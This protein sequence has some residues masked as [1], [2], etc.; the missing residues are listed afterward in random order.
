VGEVDLM[1]TSTKTAGYPV[2][3]VGKF[4]RWTNQHQVH[5]TDWLARC[6]ARG[7]ESGHRPF[8]LAGSAR[9]LELCPTCF[10]GRDWNGAGAGEP[11]ELTDRTELKLK[12]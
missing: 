12:A 7:S 6:G 8:G 5:F 11:E 2:H 10:P 1:T 4:V 9:R 3:A